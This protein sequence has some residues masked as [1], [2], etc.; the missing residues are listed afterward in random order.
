MTRK[1]TTQQTVSEIDRVWGMLQRVVAAGLLVLS[2][3][4]FCVIAFAIRMDSQGPIVFRQSRPGWKGSTFTALKFRTMLPNSEQST[5][6]GVNSGSSRITRVGRVLRSTKL[7]E[8]PQLVNIARGDMRFVGPRPI[9]KA[10]HDTLCTSIPGFERRYDVK[11]GLTSLAQVCVSDNGLDDR[12][13]Q[14]WS[15]RFE[16]ESRYM[17]H[18]SVSYD[19]LVIGLTGL[20]VMRK[21]VMR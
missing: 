14:D 8:L 17:R 21:A 11:P 2:L 16:A 20:Y 19:L 1:D 15:L 4:V 10:L 6:L 3:P 9:P 5:R 13:V 18:R 12:L 7:D